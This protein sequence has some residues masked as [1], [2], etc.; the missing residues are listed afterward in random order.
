[1]ASVQP[2]SVERAPLEWEHPRRQAG[3]GRRHCTRIKRHD[4][5]VTSLNHVRSF[6]QGDDTGHRPSRRLGHAGVPSF[7]HSTG[8]PLSSPR[9]SFSRLKRAAQT[10]AER[11]GAR[12]RGAARISGRGSG[13][14]QP[15]RQERKRASRGQRSAL[16]LLGSQRR[17]PPIYRPTERRRE[18][19]T[20][21]TRFS[22]DPIRQIE[23]RGGRNLEGVMQTSHRRCALTPL[24]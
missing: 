14:Y 9:D 20:G 12:G 24:T 3:L 17:A 7:F 21:L 2:Q 13:A 16:V 10:S 5:G 22:H 15:R 1:M 6:A 11:L 23:R 4:G 19:G 8:G 18:Q